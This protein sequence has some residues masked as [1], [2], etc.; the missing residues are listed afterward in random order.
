MGWLRYKRGL[1]FLSEVYRSKLCSR[2]FPAE[3]LSLRRRVEQFSRSEGRTKGLHH[4]G[5]SCNVQFGW[6]TERAAPPNS[7]GDREKLLL[8]A[9]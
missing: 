7:Y 3:T 6:L 5:Y 1:T 2:E 4:R 8:S 9:L